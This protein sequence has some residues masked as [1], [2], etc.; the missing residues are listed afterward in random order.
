MCVQVAKN[1]E[2]GNKVVEE[3]NLMI[4][5]KKKELAAL[6]KKLP[7]LVENSEVFAKVVKEIVLLSELVEEDEQTANWGMT[8]EE[9][10]QETQAWSKVGTKSIYV[11]ITT[12]FYKDVPTNSNKERY[13]KKIV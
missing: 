6:T 10:K 8:E 2:K 3:A 7:K 11:Y 9:A 12:A 4:A 5:E 1:E 13:K